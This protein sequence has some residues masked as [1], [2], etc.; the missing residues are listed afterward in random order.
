MCTLKFESHKIYVRTFSPTIRTIILVCIMQIQILLLHLAPG[1]S[2][3]TK[4]DKKFDIGM[5]NL[6]SFVLF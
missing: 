3:D 2:V 1:M 4:C 6:Y 5:R